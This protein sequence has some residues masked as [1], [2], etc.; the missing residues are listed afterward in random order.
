MKLRETGMEA[1]PYAVFGLFF[2]V[3]LL[4]VT[5][6]TVQEKDRGIGRAVSYNFTSFC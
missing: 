5:D 2:P 3:D 1:A 6:R 4:W